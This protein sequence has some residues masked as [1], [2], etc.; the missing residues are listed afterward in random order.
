M[1]I[2]QQ[3][4]LIAASL[5]F[6]HSILADEVISGRFTLVDHNGID[7]SEATYDG[8]LRLVFFGFT[9]CPIICP[10]TMIEVTRVMKGLGDKNNEVQPI[11][12]SIDPENDT[13]D[14]VAAYVRAFHPSIVG[15]T[16][17]PDRIAAAARSFNVTYGKTAPSSAKEASEI[18]HSSYLYLMGRNGEFID[19]FGY[20][21]KPAVILA[22]LEEF[23]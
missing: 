5:I 8:K 4:L 14:V 6:A 13:V 11:F 1:K 23:L 7:V 20:G 3:F 10:T 2:P 17:H 9:R 19:V 22:R 18:Y 12:I 16:G 15:L 21:A